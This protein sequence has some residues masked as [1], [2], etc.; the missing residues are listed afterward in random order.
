MVTKSVDIWEI[1]YKFAAECAEWAGD[2]PAARVF[3]DTLAAG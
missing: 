3:R 1:C 2:E